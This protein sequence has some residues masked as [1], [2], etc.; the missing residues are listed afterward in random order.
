[1]TMT[2]MMMMM[3]IIITILVPFN[4]YSVF[5]TPH[6]RQYFTCRKRI[7]IF[8]IYQLAILIATFYLLLWHLWKLCSLT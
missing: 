4:L 8:K 5:A 1:M 7:T 3:I 2:M 6:F